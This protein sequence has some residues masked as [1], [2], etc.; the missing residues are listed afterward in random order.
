MRAIRGIR[1]IEFPSVSRA[2]VIG[3]TFAIAGNVLISFSLNLQKLAHARLEASRSQRSH[4]QEV[5]ESEADTSVGDEAFGSEVQP[6]LS[7]PPEVER[8]ARVWHGSSS[9]AGLPPG[10]R[11]ET[12]PLMALPPTESLEIP[13]VAPT[14]GALFPGTYEGRVRRVSPL[15]RHP[16]SAKQP[17]VGDAAEPSNGQAYHGPDN[18]TDYLKSKLW[19][20]F[21]TLHRTAGI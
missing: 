21:P 1:D 15:R 8:E 7:L 12:D 3:I 18:E 10:P 16:K 11:L 20:V 14:Y 6:D 2:T 5:T 9:E 17:G 4:G 19:Y 13:P